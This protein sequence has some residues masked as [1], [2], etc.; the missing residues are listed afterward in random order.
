MALVYID[1]GILINIG[2]PG[3]EEIET[4]D[5]RI[6]KDNILMYVNY[7]NLLNEEELTFNITQD[8]YR[9]DIRI[10][11][12]DETR[13]CLRFLDEWTSVKKKYNIS[14]TKDSIL[15]T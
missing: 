14:I 7:R 2:I 12:Y 15:L 11:H 1:G 13:V 3:Y 10:I 9:G 6:Y 5:M 8:D 4:I